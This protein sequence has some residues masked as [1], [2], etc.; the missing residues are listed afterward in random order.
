MGCPSGLIWILRGSHAKIKKWRS[1]PAKSIPNP[2]PSMQHGRPGK[3]GDDG[4]AFIQ[5]HHK[6]QYSD[7]YIDYIITT[8]NIQLVVINVEGLPNDFSVSRDYLNVE[9]QGM[10]LAIWKGFIQMFSI[11]QFKV[12]ADQ[13]SGYSTHLCQVSPSLKD[14]LLL[15]PLLCAS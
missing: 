4:F 8:C 13:V 6:L 3:G 10:S 14:T 9:P 15:C 12:T 11:R 1:V 7:M 5:E 2:F